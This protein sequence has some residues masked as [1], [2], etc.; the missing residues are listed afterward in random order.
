[1]NWILISCG[2]ES[3][4]LKLNYQRG[5]FL[6]CGIMISVRISLQVRT[7]LCI[8]ASVDNEVR[9][10]LSPYALEKKIGIHPWLREGDEGRERNRERERERETQR[11]R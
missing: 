5:I 6:K 9:V 2:H 10:P 8:K 3:Y 1:M 4:L 7:W 11:Q